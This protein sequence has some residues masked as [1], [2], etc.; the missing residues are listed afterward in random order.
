MATGGVDV[1]GR[2]LLPAYLG[3]IEKFMFGREKTGHCRIL[4]IAAILIWSALFISGLL[5]SPVFAQSNI[6]LTGSIYDTEDGRP[7]AGAAVRLIATGHSTATDERGRFVFENL[8]IGAYTAEISASGYKNLVVDEITVV[9]DMASRISIKLIPI[10]YRLGKI[11]VRGRRLEMR[12]DNVEVFLR[13]QIEHSGARDLGEL[14]AN[15]RGLMVQKSGR[16]GGKAQVRIRGSASKQVLVLLDGQR[17]NPASDGVADLSTIPIEMVERL[18]VHKGG[19]SA[20]FGPDALGGAINIITHSALLNDD[21]SASLAV[22]GSR[23]NGRQLRMKVQNLIPSEKL[24]TRFSFNRRRSDGDFYF[25]YKTEPTLKTYTGTRMNN[26]FDSYNYYMTGGYRF[27]DR[28]N[29]TYSSQYYRSLSG[30][31]DRASN[32]N[33]N[34]GSDDRR[35]MISTALSYFHLTDNEIK[36]EFGYTQ[37]R[38]HY[39][40]DISTRKFNSRY[41]NDIFTMRIGHNFNPLIGNRLKYGVEFRRDI[42]YH[43]DLYRPSQ[44]MGKT[45]RDDMALFFHNEQRFDISQTVLADNM[46]LNGSVR[47]DWINT[48]RDSISPRD[49]AV[50][51][52]TD[53]LSPKIG[54]VI[55]KGEKTG[56]VIRAGYGKSTRLPSI[57]ALFWIGDTQAK[58]NPD[59]RPERSEHS[60]VELELKTTIGVIRLSGGITYFHSYISDLVVWRPSVGVWRPINLNRAQITGH[61][62][63]IEMNLFENNIAIRFQ[64]SITTGL[65]KT[66]G[67]TSYNKRLVFSP[68]YTR[69][70]ELKLD[71]HLLNASYSIRWVDSI[72]I[73]ESNTKYYDGYRLDDLLVGLKFN[74]ARDWRLRFDFRLNNVRDV[75]YILLTHYPMPGR[76][77]ELVLGVNYEINGK[78]R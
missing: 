7:V 4:K 24:T 21:F 77:W 58:G 43:A 2:F 45:L 16:S 44:S 29:V 64:N 11:T 46:T 50:S 60:D 78:Q 66:E 18:E 10:S 56:Y 57:N 19:A 22:A 28:Y 5:L 13:H 25:N 37:L 38:Q 34:A 67:H 48:R 35:V 63:F 69:T 72:Y 41:T 54:L 14:L 39:F 36:A 59:L 30:L 23:W 51:R 75:S 71:Y 33:E 9:S 68:H 70:L 26:Y 31:P 6:S 8:P 53:I 27:S 17:L 12:S 62:D 40:D 15:I 42:L 20:E 65:N 55:N 74:I 49:S 61:E 32:Q 1:M 47:L 52:R 76:E 3:L 73:L